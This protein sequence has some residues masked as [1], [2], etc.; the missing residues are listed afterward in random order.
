MAEP[1]DRDPNG[2]RTELIA[3]PPADLR[4]EPPVVARLI[5]EIRSDGSRTIA[6]GAMEDLATGARTAVEARGD[7]PLQL[8]IALGRA[9]TQLPRMGARQ[10]I[11]GLLGKRRER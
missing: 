1:D 3:A 10:A 7:S 9:L 2:D 5:V 11:R 6:R 4:A 8:A